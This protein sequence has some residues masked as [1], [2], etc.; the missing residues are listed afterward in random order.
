M[1]NNEVVDLFTKKSQ[2]NII[3]YVESDNYV[4]IVEEIATQKNICVDEVL[5]ILK[6]EALE[7]TRIFKIHSRNNPSYTYDW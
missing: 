2:H 4:E 1:I 5:N 6:Y 3:G 7:A